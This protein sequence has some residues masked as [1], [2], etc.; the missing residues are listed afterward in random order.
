M[1]MLVKQYM[2]LQFD[3]DSEESYK[4]K[5]TKT[6][7]IVVKCNMSIERHAIWPPNFPGTCVPDRG[8]G[9][10]QVVQGHSHSSREE[11]EMVQGGV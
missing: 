1:H 3:R 11:G 7:G 8:S 5:L 6:G 2:R 4:E 10:E 9:E